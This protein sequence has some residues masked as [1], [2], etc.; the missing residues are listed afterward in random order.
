M[1]NKFWKTL[2][3]NGCIFDFLSLSMLW[4]GAPPRRINR[5]GAREAYKHKAGGIVY[6]TGPDPFGN[7]MPLPTCCWSP[8]VSTQPQVLSTYF[9]YSFYMPFV[10]D[11]FLSHCCLSS[12]NLLLNEI[13]KPLWWVR[14]P[15]RRKQS[16]RNTL[17]WIVVEDKVVHLFSSQVPRKISLERRRRRNVNQIKEGTIEWVWEFSF[18]R[19]LSSLLF[20]FAGPKASRYKINCSSWFVIKRS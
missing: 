2:D 8:S 5:L 10:W 17:I 1:Q 7:C 15:E 3:T 20:H 14:I 6:A 9:I 12:C 4:K 18:F 13:L 19:C 11:C 16:H